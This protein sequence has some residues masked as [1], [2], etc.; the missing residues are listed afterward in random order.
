MSCIH[1][2]AFSNFDTSETFTRQR[3]GCVWHLRWEVRQDIREGDAQRAPAV[4]AGEATQGWRRCSE[5]MLPVWCSLLLREMRGQQ[6]W[7]I[8]PVR[9]VSVHASVPQQ[10]GGVGTIRAVAEAR[11]LLLLEVMSRTAAEGEAGHAA[12]L[13]AP[14]R[15]VG[16]GGRV[17]VR[18]V[19]GRGTMAVVQWQG[20]VQ[21]LPGGGVGAQRGLAAQGGMF[22]PWWADGATK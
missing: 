10:R 2:W 20:V 21:R 9:K 19:Q 6:Q 18:V 3:R 13:A 4:G 17:D 16:V 1:L 14:G 11:I 5:R 8:L 12:P 22:W 15:A 7:W